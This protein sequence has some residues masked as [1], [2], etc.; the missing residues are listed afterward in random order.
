VYEPKHHALNPHSL[1]KESSCDWQLSCSHF[2][3]QEFA[4]ALIIST[5]GYA[6]TNECYNE[7]FLSI[8]LL[9]YNEHRYYNERG[10]I[11]MADVA[12]A[13]RVFPLCLEL[14]SSSL[15]SFVRFNYQF[16]LVVCLFTPLAAKIFF[17]YSTI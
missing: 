9:C 13:C 3:H 4:Q 11:L 1:L 7:Q 10:G 15:L 14:Q 8:K 5:V 17:N 6:T 16:S 12:R 2:V